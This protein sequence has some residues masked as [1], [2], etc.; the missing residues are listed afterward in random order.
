MPILFFTQL[1][2]LAFGLDARDAG[3]RR[4]VVSARAGAGEDRH[5]GRRPPEADERRRRPRAARSR[6]PA[7]VPELPMAADARSRRRTERRRRR[8]G[9]HGRDASRASAST[10]ATAAATSPARSTSR[11]S[12]TGPRE[13][14]GGHGVVD[15]PRLQVHVLEPRPGAD[16]EGHQGAGP[17]PR[18]RRRLLA[19]PAREDLPR[20]PAQRAGLN[21]YLCELVSIR[22]QVSWVHTDKAAATEKAKAI[23][24][25]GVLP[26]R[27][28]TSRSSRCS[29][30]STRRRSSWAAASPA[31]PAALEIAD[32]GFPVHL[33]ER[34]PSIGGH[35]AQFDKTFPTLDC[36][37]C[38]LTPKMVDGRAATRTSRCSPGA[39]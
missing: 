6:E 5:R 28:S 35:M 11:R 32:A 15:R 31:S 13:R 8:P 4:G 10:S 17:D 1:M 23:V 39:R 38:I 12:A 29:R 22:E 20:A 34:E 14:L 36:A 7:S 9:R 16:R 21:P 27:A 37:A 25:G 30:R 3:H 26:R 24:A 18:R 33:V 2:G 19:A